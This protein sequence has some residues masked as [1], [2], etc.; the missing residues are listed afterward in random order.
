MKRDELLEP[1]RYDVSFGWVGGYEVEANHM[2][3]AIRKVKEMLHEDNVGLNLRGRMRKPTVR[4]LK[5]IDGRWT[6]IKSTK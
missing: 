5:E 2:F 3:D 6:V 1:G 4:K